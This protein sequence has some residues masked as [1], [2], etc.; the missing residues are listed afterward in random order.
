TVMTMMNILESKGHLKR[1]VVDRAYVYRAAHPKAK[2]IKAMLQ[3]F[4]NRVFDGSAEPLLVQLVKDRHLT[5]S[6]LEKIARTIQEGPSS[7]PRA[8]PGKQQ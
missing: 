6:D 5:Q 1:K 8:A 2:V 4:V 3:D 7:T